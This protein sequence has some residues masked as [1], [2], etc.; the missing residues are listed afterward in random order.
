MKIYTRAGDGGSTE[1]LRGKRV[2]KSNPAP[3]ACGTVD[4]L[5]AELGLLIGVLDGAAGERLIPELRRIQRRLF[6]VGSRLTAL[7]A[8]E[9]D[10]SGAAALNMRDNEWIEASIDEM[11]TQLKPLNAFV[12]PGGCSAAIQSHRV[13]TVCRR[14]E[15]RVVALSEHLIDTTGCHHIKEEIRYLNRLADYL[16]VSARFCNHCAGEP[17]FEW[18]GERH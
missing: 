14:A 2:S 17:E 7:N 15:R 12:L 13:R 18:R 1:L 4:E 6:A 10:A 9:A 5:N 8:S 16:F 11:E 3:E